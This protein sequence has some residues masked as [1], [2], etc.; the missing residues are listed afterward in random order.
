MEQKFIVI[1]DADFSSIA[2]G[3]IEP[4]SNE[5]RI[6]V[7]AE[8]ITA[9]TTTGSGTYERGTAV[10]ISATANTGYE[11]VSWDDGNNQS[12]RTINVQSNMTYTANFERLTINIT[13]M[14]DLHKNVS[15][16]LQVG[17][18]NNTEIEGD[19]TMANYASSSTFD[20]SDKVDISEY[21]GKTMRITIPVYTTSSGVRAG[22]GFA[23]FTANP[24]TDKTI[25][26]SYQMPKNEE[27][28]SKSSYEKIE[29]V[30]P[31]SAVYLMVT[32]YKSTHE[33]GNKFDCR[34]LE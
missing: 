13:D 17:T 26:K 32:W 31:N 8:P 18:N 29:I 10:T 1:P 27:G 21:R 34:I 33:L 12:T 14:F 23:F 25:L 28:A 16:A 5:K 19:L 2:A 6:V 20:R 9:G 11:F 7:K 4:I 15:S 30:V 22:F 24:D 3:K